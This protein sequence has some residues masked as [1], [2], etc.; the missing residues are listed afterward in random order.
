M[1]KRKKV[2]VKPT[3][4]S[5]WLYG[6]QTKSDTAAATF[7][8]TD[9]ESGTAPSKTVI[10]SPGGIKPTNAT[11]SL[12]SGSDSSYADT[13]V[14]N[15]LITGNYS[16]TRKRSTSPKGT[17]KSKIVGILLETGV[18]WCW[19]MPTTR[20]NTISADIKTEAGLTEITAFDPD[21]H[22]YNG[23]AF[24]LKADAGGFKAGQYVD[25]TSLRK[26]FTDASTGKK[27]RI[28]AKLSDA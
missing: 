27:V 13:S 7:G 12:A 22:V 3:Q 5:N 9:C 15:A 6:F 25:K 16:I 11:K 8:H 18:Y 10:F 17:A 21:K 4:Q 23:N 2:A 28:Y 24:I 1:A 20:W 14:I 26:T 19:R